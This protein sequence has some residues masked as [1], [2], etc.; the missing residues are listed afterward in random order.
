MTTQ[1]IKSKVDDSS[2]EIDLKKL[3]GVLL[4]SKW[5]ILTVTF[6]FSIAGVVYALLSTPIYKADALLQIEQKSSSGISALVGDMGDAFSSKS[7]SDTEIEII[8]SRMILG[9]TVD[10]FN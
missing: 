2:D 6:A 8:K 5:L 10:K 3:F 9:D 7:S 1:N 4:D